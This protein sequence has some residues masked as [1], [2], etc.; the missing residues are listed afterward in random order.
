M[1]LRERYAA[2]MEWLYIGAIG[3][4]AGALVLITLAIPY[5]VFMR[6]VM[7]SAASWPEPFAVL[8][9][10][11]FT[12]IGGAAAY[13]AGVH[14][15]V[16]VLTDLLGPRSRRVV[17]FVADSCM[18]AIAAFMVWY[19]MQLVQVTMRQT[20]GEFPSLP[21]GISYL[22]IPLGGVMTLLFIIERMWLGAPPATSWIHRDQP[23]AE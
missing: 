21:V 6:Y 5:G 17:A 4:S 12:F 16:G 10:V 15:A 2:T 19:G 14:I 8:M 9:M 22:P 13:R 11:L 18:L 3:I 23:L 20:I 7:N 1:S